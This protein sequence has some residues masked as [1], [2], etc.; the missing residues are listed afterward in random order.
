MPEDIITEES[1]KTLWDELEVL[2]AADPL[3]LGQMDEPGWV[4]RVGK[5]YQVIKGA[6]GKNRY[7][8]FDTQELIESETIL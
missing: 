3:Q 4:V 7:L 5:H 2:L 8:P 6:D 1:D